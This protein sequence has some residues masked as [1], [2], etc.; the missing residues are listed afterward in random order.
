MPLLLMHCNTYVNTYGTLLRG[1]LDYLVSAHFTGIDQALEVS[2]LHN[3]TS[4]SLIL[5][6][7]LSVKQIIFIA[8]AAVLEVVFPSTLLCV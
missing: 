7:L 1:P 4:H 6:V 2:L 3:S 5:T 8:A